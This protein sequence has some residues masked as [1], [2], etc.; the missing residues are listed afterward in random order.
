M[1]QQ[2]VPTCEGV[3]SF[4]VFVNPPLVLGEYLDSL[5]VLLHAVHFVVLHM[6]EIAVTYVYI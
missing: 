4:I 1:Q 3:I 6:R 5:V 2:A